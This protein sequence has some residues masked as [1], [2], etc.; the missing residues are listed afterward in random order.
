MLKN[1]E[2]KLDNDL[3]DKLMDTKEIVPKLT[4]YNLF[5]LR[6]IF[7]GFDERADKVLD[8]FRSDKNKVI[9]KRYMVPV[10]NPNYPFDK[11]I[12][13][14]KERKESYYVD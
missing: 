10:V 7:D 1:I 9:R 3:Y 13:D 11:L 4:D 5:L 8:N 12:S 14:I 6:K 2:K